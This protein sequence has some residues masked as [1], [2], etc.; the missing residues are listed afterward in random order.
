MKE[1][2]VFRETP[3]DP[4]LEVAN[5]SVLISVYSEQRHQIDVMQN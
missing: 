1:K 2:P 5:V 3:M 4:P